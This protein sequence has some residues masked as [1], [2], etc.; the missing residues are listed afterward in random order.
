MDAHFHQAIET[1]LNRL[2]QTRI[3]VIGDFFLDHYLVIDPALRE[4]SLETGKVANQVVKV[5]HSPGAAG[6][7]TSNLAALGVGHILALGVIGDD[8]NGYDLKQDLSRM[9]VDCRYLIQDTSVFTPTYTKPL[10]KLSD[11]IEEQERLDIKNRQEM[12]PGLQQ[13]LLTNLSQCI[14]EIDGLIVSDQVEEANFGVIT[15]QVRA[16]IIELGQKFPEKIIF[17]DSRARIGLFKNVI[18]KPNKYEAYRAVWEETA[19]TVS[20][21]EAEQL[22]KRL[23]Q[24]SQR[25][26]IVTLEAAGALI[27]TAGETTYMPGISISGK[28]DPVGAGD[29]FA[30]GT[31]SGLCAH[32][33]LETAVF[34]GNL[35]ASIT[36][37]KIGTTGTASPAEVRQRNNELQR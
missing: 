11:T 37:Q 30:A 18:L 28:I 17:V 34:M 12:L 13:Q 19:S 2:P 10:K 26:V 32:T 31:V 14:H 29:A 33:S 5:Y 7:I 23:A 3:G 25:P 16:Q 4:I 8:G 27:C 6:S 21:T 36:V 22:G 1:I 20:Q 24:Q 9:G 35:V 15:D